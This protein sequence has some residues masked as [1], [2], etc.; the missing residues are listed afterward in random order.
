MYNA[1]KY[2]AECLD[3]VLA[4]TFKNFEVIVVDDCSTDSSCAIVESYKP[5]FSGRLTLSHMERNSGGGL[6]RNKGI[7][8]ARGE[9]IQFVDSDDML[10]PNAL[11]ENFVLAKKYD[12]DVIYRTK[13]Y[14][15]DENGLVDK[16]INCPKYFDK[17]VLDDDLPGRVR[18]IIQKKY[19]L[20]PWR[21][22]V[23]RTFLIE[24]EIFFPHVRINEDLIWSYGVF[25]NAKRFLHAP[26]PIYLYRQNE[27]SITHVKRAPKEAIT[28]FISPLILG[29]KT[30]DK[31][32][33]KIE[34]FQQNPQYRHAMLDY[35]I[36]KCFDKF[37][38]HTLQI[39]PTTFYE[40]IKQEFGERL[41]EQD[42][43]VSALATAFNTQQKINTVNQQRFQQFAMQAQKRIAQLEAELKRLQT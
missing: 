24:H 37:F 31:F 26:N 11:E 42:V 5:K 15:M 7:L 22:F 16:I 10:T 34:F 35:F 40:T 1:E 4:Q 36:Y 25:F 43:L 8:L 2:I 9:Y 32:M 21:S 39:S 30:I 18:D 14:R 28:I 12:T 27:S 23:K 19:W 33:S 13:Y 17:L 29:L 6:P 38:K 41:G 3:S 20:G